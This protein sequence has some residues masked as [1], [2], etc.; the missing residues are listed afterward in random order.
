MVAPGPK[1]Q[2]LRLELQAILPAP[3]SQPFFDSA[4]LVLVP[5]L[6]LVLLSEQEN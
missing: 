1:H 3:L 5:V 2:Q 4:L 6:K